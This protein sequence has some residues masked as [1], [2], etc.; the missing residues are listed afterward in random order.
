MEWECT[1]THEEGLQCHVPQLHTVKCSSLISA[2]WL[3]GTGSTVASSYTL[4]SAEVIIQKLPFL[5]SMEW[6][7]KH[8][9]YLGN[10]V[11]N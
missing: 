9:S 7:M 11:Q 1:A 2:H 8:T 6:K 3:F 5:D 4:L 10:V